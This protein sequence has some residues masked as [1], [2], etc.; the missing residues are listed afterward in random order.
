MNQN[1][2]IR[3]FLLQVL[4]ANSEDKSIQWL[5]Q[6]AQEIQESTSPTPFFLAFSQASRFFSK[7]LLQLSEE[8]RNQA[9]QLV[10]GFEP[11]HWNKLQAARSF[12]LLHLPQER[13]SWFSA[14]NQL[15][16]TGDMHEQQALFAALPILPFQEDLLTRAIDGCRTNMT[17]VF[18]AIALN[19]PYPASYF[20]E[21][22]WNQLVLK[23]VFMQRPLYRIQGIDRRRN[24]ALAGIASD[25]A[26][27]RWAAGRNVMP[28]LWRLV[29]PFV[30]DHYLSDLKKVINSDDE[31][32]QKA[33]ALVLYQSD[34]AAAKVLLEGFPHLLEQVESDQINWESIGV[35]FQESR[36]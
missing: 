10:S 8:S 35:Y 2:E 19:N 29:V 36:I 32:G 3:N 17:L 23:A 30:N 33:G 14:M 26:H 7:E 24:S 31:L 15:F 25:F 9:A 6:K 5:K 1:L 28:E 27:E 11:A 34:F 22:N 4:V 21:A 18:D 20:P 13:E 12:F 16:E